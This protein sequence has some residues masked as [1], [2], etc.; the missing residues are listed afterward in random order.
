VPW[1]VYYS[2]GGLVVDD[3]ECDLDAQECVDS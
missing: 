2:A 1:P 3:I